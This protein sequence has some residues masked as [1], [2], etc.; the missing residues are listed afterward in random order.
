MPFMIAQRQEN[1]LS[2]IVIFLFYYSAYK[3]P[4]NKLISNH[5]SSKILEHLPELVGIGNPTEFLKLII[6]FL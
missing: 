5:Q 4:K 3:M 6:I 1:I 2:V